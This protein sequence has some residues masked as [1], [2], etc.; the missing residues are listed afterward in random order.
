MKDA[1]TPV[2]LLAERIGLTVLILVGT[3][4]LLGHIYGGELRSSRFYG[5]L[6][7]LAEGSDGA[8]P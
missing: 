3:S 1:T 7:R 8:D 2:E 4:R 5:P 6:F